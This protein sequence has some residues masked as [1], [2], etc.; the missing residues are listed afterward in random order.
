MTVSYYR[1]KQWMDAKWTDL[2]FFKDFTI[3]F[4]Q[5]HDESLSM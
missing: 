4:G 5:K 2:T 1:Q 3:S